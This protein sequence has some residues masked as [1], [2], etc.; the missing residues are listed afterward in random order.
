MK[1]LLLL[2]FVFYILTPAQNLE[3]RIDSL[4]GQMTL[5]EKI[6]QLHKEGGMNTQD[7]QRL[8]IP[9]FVMADGPHGVRDGLVTSFPVGIGMAATWDTDLAYRVGEA[10][11][12]EFRGKGKHQMLGPAMDMTRD[13]RN[14]RTPESGGED[15]Y[16][17]A[18]INS[19]VTQGVQSTPAIATIK[20]YN[21]KHK[22]NNRTNNNYIFTQRLLM[23]HYGLNFRKS[24]QDAGAFSVMSAYNLVNGDQ[25]AESYNLL[26]YILRRQWGFPFYV[27]SDWGGIKN[28]RKAML[29][30]N[31][32]CMGSDQYQNDLLALVTSGQLS[33][34][35]IDAAVRNVL[36]T[37]IVSGMM[38]YIP[39]GNPNDVNS[40]A[41]QQLNLEAGMKSLVLLKN[42]NN[43]L[44]IN[45]DTI[46][47]VAVIGPN[48]NVMRT[49]GTGSSWVE[50]H[51][52]ISPRK[53]IENILGVS[54]VLYAEGCTIAGGLSADYS[55]A[56]Q[57]AVQSQV[58]FFFGGLDPTQEGEGLD[59][60]NGSI[61]LPGQQKQMINALAAVNPNIVVILVSGGITS[62]DAYIENVKGL[63][64][65][66]YPGQEGGNAIAKVL[67]GEYNPS[68]KLPVTIP[69]ND[70]QLGAL[71][72]DFDFRNDFGCGYRWFD[73]MQ[74]IPRFAFGFGLSYSSF[75]FSDF[76]I[77]TP[78]VEA[79]K[80]VKAQLTVSNMS[81]HEGT[82][83]VQIYLSRPVSSVYRDMKSLIAF[84]KVYIPA[85]GTE[86]VTFELQPDDL[87]CFNETAGVYAIETG[88][89]ILRAGNSSD[90]L[91]LEA[92]FTLTQAELKPDLQIASIYS[93]PR[94]P[95]PGQKVQFAATVVNRGSG[96]SPAGAVHRVDFIVNGVPVSRSLS[97][98]AS[99]PGGGMILLNGDTPE[100]SSFFWEA[101][102][103]GEFTV[104]AK[105]NPDGAVSE[106]YADNNVKQKNFKVYPQPPQNYAL[107]K[108]VY[109]SSVEAPGLEGHRAVD[110]SYGSRWSSAFSDP[111]H[112]IISFGSEVSF[113]LVRLTWEAAYGKEYYVQSSMDSVNWTTLRYTNNGTGGTEDIAVSTTAKYLRLLLIRRATEWGYSLYEIEV[114][115]IT[116]ADE[117]YNNGESTP[118]G[119]EL[120]QNFPNPFNPSTRIS[121][122]LPEAGNIS[123]TIYDALGREAATAAVGEYQQGTHSVQFDAAGLASGLYLCRL[124]GPWG[125]TSARKMLLV[126]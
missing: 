65:A 80:R 76:T 16:L 31:D 30:G 92:A 17:N 94:Y 73:Q 24:V 44:P 123:L 25:A 18:M 106:I 4:L 51:Y 14:G 2:V 68:G 103:P 56:L 96:A 26:T 32:I 104:E 11:G 57:K 120:H 85:G 110:G 22:Q 107:K 95:H 66:F 109:V 10:M 20:H 83:T 72:T 61:E 46:R 97:F 126:R 37:K 114:F 40:T 15:P 67:F 70:A 69:K 36:R 58:V 74:Y 12:K 7:N 90:N 111:Q 35:A 45:K 5:A 113:N 6:L 108:T 3:Q 115:A 100:G 59:R 121:F 33:V 27:V 48:A 50:P 71:I 88:E 39:S 125:A 28:S 52:S 124:T 19:Y 81:S 99:I 112:I 43:I 117:G 79:G 55:D 47:S 122:T 98:S 1:K 64:Q 87:Y 42:I 41:H 105:V 82:E 78:T 75:A 101:G 93:I 29:A 21:G 119:F 86:T 62:A 60:A 63:M 23:E 34:T 8:R 89:Y 49:D 118:Q 38:D 91:P 53:G 77:L 54:K 13:P 84:K 116:R 102:A 9:G